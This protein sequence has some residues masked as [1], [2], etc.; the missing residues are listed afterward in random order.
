MLDKRSQIIFT[1]RISLNHT[2]TLED[3]GAELGITKE[4][5]RQLSIVAEDK[6]RQ[7]LQTP[8]FTPIGW[9][10]H[11]LRQILGAAIPSDNPQLI[12]TI[13]RF[14]T[15]VAAPGNERTL[16]FLLWLAGPYS[17]DSST[18]WLL[19]GE[20]PG[21]E[22][23]YEFRDDRGCVD[24]PRLQQRLAESGLLP[25]AQADWIERIGR[26][27]QFEGN[28][29]IWTGTV[30]DKA[31]R[32]LAI[33]GQPA[34]P[35]EIVNAINEGH[36][37]RATRS[38]LF[39][40]SRVM[41]VDMNRVGLRS[42]GMEEY[43]TIAEE[44]DQELESRGGSANLDDLVATLVSRFNLREASVR[45]YVNAPMF[46]LEGNTI[47]RRVSGDPQ[48]PVAPITETAGCYAIDPDTIVWHIEVTSDTLRGSGR[49][50]PAS[51]AAWLGVEPGGRSA[52][53]Y[54]S[55]TVSVT[56]PGTSAHGPS[57]GSIR[58]LVESAGGTAG[59]EAHIY[60]HRNSL[61]ISLTRIDP[62]KVNDSSGLHRLSLLTGIPYGDN[63]VSFLHV[64][65]LA[66]CTR[67]TR[68][69]IA[70]EFKRRGELALAA[71]VPAESDSPEL[72][73]AIDALRDLF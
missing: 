59:D 73:A 13:I 64:L 29:L 37:V 28:W 54:E 60:F 61:T 57:L 15:G 68:A 11:S 21:H 6:I 18:G 22:I 44:M 7:A 39:E 66:L 19:S 31:I 1:G 3:L 47:R 69:A 8:R 45:F 26:L 48:P 36:D 10:A 9:R 27:K 24:L 62:E 33:W 58:S 46:F 32:I 20:M 50:L 12:A 16:D 67:G 34:T 42:W 4:R 56:W 70:A 35:E 52:L 51:I 63:E 65:G 14:T 53:A 49:M 40:D 25:A 71:L 5:V 30:T 23:L 43:S 38:R 72:D 17:W 41:R 2:R 55:G